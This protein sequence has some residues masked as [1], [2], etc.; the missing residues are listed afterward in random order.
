MEH[1]FT[2]YNLL[3]QSFQHA[4]G[5]HTFFAL[6][7]AILLLLFAFA[8]RAALAKAQ[9]PAVP[10]GELGVRNIAELLL[11]LVV[12]QS[13]QIIGKQGRKYVP[14]FATFFM[15]ILLSN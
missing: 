3:P 6:V 14:F 11:Q 10:A 1:P 15:F 7:A 13:D 2:W 8:A 9:D 4:I 12:N 5:D